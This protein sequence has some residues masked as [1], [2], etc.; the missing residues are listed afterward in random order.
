MDSWDVVEHKSQDDHNPTDECVKF[1]RAVSDFSYLGQR[2][3][4]M[5][6]IKQCFAG[7][8]RGQTFLARMF[9]FDDI[10]QRSKT[11][12]SYSCETTTKI[13]IY[14]FYDSF[15]PCDE[16]WVHERLVVSKKALIKI[17]R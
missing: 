7:I 2:Q 15:I 9:Q 13:I 17:Q 16:E 8:D 5:R 6:G 3:K 12:T 4:R 10:P 1:K 14:L 11:T